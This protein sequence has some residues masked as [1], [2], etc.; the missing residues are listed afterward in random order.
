MLVTRKSN[1]N[2]PPRV[3][4]YGR[5]GVGKSTF[6][7]RAENPIFIS[8]EG[9]TDLLTR[10][11]GSPVDE[12]PNVHD[13]DSVMNA[14]KAL[15]SQQHDFKTLVLDSA[16]WIEKV[17]HAK[18]IGNSNKDIIRVNGGYWQD[19]ARAKSF[20]K[21]SLSCFLICAKSATWRSSSLRT[22]K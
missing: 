11:D 19:F 18:I 2:K 15:I 6:G 10:A 3:L 9:G 22:R 16:D 7:A 4:I 21:T 1:P 20:T 5:E 8:P 13:W 14:V 17:C 12:M